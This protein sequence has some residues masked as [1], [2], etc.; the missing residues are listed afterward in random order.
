MIADE[1]F[2]AWLDGELDGAEAEK[3][4]AKVAADPELQALAAQ[5]RALAARLTSAFRRL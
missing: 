2:F 3:M 5:H 1:K 4:A